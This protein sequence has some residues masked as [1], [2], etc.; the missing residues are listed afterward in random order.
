MG[1]KL[2]HARERASL[3]APLVKNPPAIREAWVEKIPAGGHGTPLQHSCLD[4]TW[5]E[6]TEDLGGLHKADGVSR[7]QARLSD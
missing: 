6:W 4:F 1:S 5:I 7:S 3:V 2:L